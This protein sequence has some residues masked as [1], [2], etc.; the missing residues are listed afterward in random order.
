MGMT[1][2]FNTGSVVARLSSTEKHDALRELIHNAPVFKEIGSQDAFEKAVIARERLQTT[3][4]GHGVAVAHGRA[5]GVE[6]VLIALGVSHAGIPWEA[7]DSE[8]VRLLFVIASPLHVS[9]DYL[10]VLSTLVR[11][12]RDCGQRDALLAAGSAEEI[13][14]R[15]LDSFSAGLARAK[16]PVASRLR[17]AD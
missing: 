13:R 3:G 8:P 4:L 12:M 7:P 2:C 5:A 6:R 9:L 14:L 10:Q 15:I 1:H 11:C 16:D 17:A